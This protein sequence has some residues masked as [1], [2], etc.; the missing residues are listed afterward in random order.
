MQPAMAEEDAY[1]GSLLLAQAQGQWEAMQ[2]AGRR[3]ARTGTA[4][5]GLEEEEFTVHGMGLPTKYADEVYFYTAQIPGQMLASLRRPNKRIEW[6]KIDILVYS[7]DLIKPEEAAK[8]LWQILR[9]HI[10]MC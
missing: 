6:E 8:P 2:D 7:V 9:R 3:F 10:W 4:G 5:G 1:I